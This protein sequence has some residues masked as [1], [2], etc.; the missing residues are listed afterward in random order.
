M[1]T[2][3]TLHYR[4]YQFERSAFVSLEFT[5]Q[6]R[7]GWEETCA[8]GTVIARI[9]S[10]ELDIQ[11]TERVSW[12]EQA[13]AHLNAL[14]EGDKP[15]NIEVA[16]LAVEQ[17]RSALEV[18][19]PELDRVRSLH[20]QGLATAEESEIAEGTWQLRKLDLQ[21]AEAE[22]S[23]LKAGARPSE[24]A[25]A[26]VIVASVEEELDAIQRKSSE[27]LIATPIAGQLLTGEERSVGPS[28]VAGAVVHARV[29]REDTMVVQILVDQRLRGK[30]D[31]GQS[32][33]VHIPGLIGPD[34]EG[35]VAYVGATHRP[36]AG[37]Q[38]FV[39]RAVVPNSDGCL[40]DGMRG[41]AR[42]LGLRQPILMAWID[43]FQRTLHREGWAPREWLRNW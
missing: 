1:L 4:L 21:L 35:H 18:F 29:I 40:E 2:G 7:R 34:T 37:Q 42:I 5:D 15:A 27:T 3:E 32:V 8:A 24:I 38:I 33:R 14:R 9:A 20:A 16:A 23:A 17:A 25:E 22:L 31:P 26:E 6:T 10:S 28:Q 39:V 36:L 13:R 43:D 19:E 41:H 11:M 12:L 30:V